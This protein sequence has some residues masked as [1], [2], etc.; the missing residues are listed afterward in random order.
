M[1]A[2]YIIYTRLHVLVHATSPFLGKRVKAYL[3]VESPSLFASWS[4]F[5]VVDSEVV[6]LPDVVDSKVVD[7]PNVVD[8]DRV[9]PY[10][11]SRLVPVD[12]DLPSLA[13]H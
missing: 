3:E 7:L 4:L 12:A 13:P 5:D 8:S 9:P 11:S 6:D 2:Q 10:L 1:H